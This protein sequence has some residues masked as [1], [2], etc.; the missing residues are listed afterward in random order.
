MEASILLL[1]SLVGLS[2][3]IMFIVRQ[4]L[5]SNEQYA[6]IEPYTGPGVEKLRYWIT[7]RT[8]LRTQDLYRIKGH[9]CVMIEGSVVKVEELFRQPKHHVETIT[10]EALQES[11]P[12]NVA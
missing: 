10:Q 4:Q 3:Y 5:V 12:Q 7:C 2:A 11:L 1:C 9:W 6:S 8:G